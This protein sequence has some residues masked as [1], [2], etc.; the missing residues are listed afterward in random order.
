MR[1]FWMKD[2]RTI[3]GAN[4]SSYTFTVLDSSAGG[5]YTCYVANNYGYVVSDVAAVVVSSVVPPAISLQP[6]SVSVN[7]G[8]VVTLKVRATGSGTLGYQWRKGGVAVPGAVS[9]VYS[10][11]A[12]NSS[13]AGSYDCVVTNSAS[14]VASAKASVT[15]RPGTFHGLVDRKADL[16]GNLGSRIDL[17]STATGACSLKITSGTVSYAATGQLSSVKASPGSLQVTVPK[18]GVVALQLDA[19]G[20]T[21][22]GSL[23]NAAGTSTAAV[24]AWRNPWAEVSGNASKLKG[25]YSLYFAQGNVLQ[26]LPQGYGYASFTVN[27]TSG[28]LV[29]TGA[30]ADGSSITGSTFVGKDGRV[31]V[32]SPAYSNRGSLAGTLSVSA[33]PMVKDNSVSGAVTWLKPAVAGDASYPSGFGPVSLK[34]RGGVYTAPPAGGRVLGLPAGAN[35]GTLTFKSG[36]LALDVNQ[37]VTITNPSTTGVTN[38]VSVASNANGVKLSSLSA[39]SGRF[40]GEFTLSG[41]ARKAQFS[42]QIVNVAGIPEGYGFFLL[43]KTPAAGETATTALS[44]SGQVLLK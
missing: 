28:G 37:P 22:T 41:T 9:S 33:A 35:N 1:Y 3:S 19:T 7:A 40:A 4:S 26:S 20:S 30:L 25:A 24:N 39:A 6:S 21:F 11:S 43:P 2:G 16:N 27:G 10:F 17:T 36:G 12:V 18:L 13:S 34:A 5:N 23:K 29:M 14:S 15:V 31:L 8:G 38:T 42:G 44:L 32:Y